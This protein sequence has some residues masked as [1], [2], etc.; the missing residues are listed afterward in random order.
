VIRL[1]LVVLLSLFA[2]P[3]FAADA[4]APAPDTI[5]GI[6][7]S[8]LAP[9][10]ATLVA[11][12]ASWAILQLAGWLRTR[13][14]AEWARALEARLADHVATAVRST[15]QTLRPTLAAAAADGRVTAEEA[16]QLREVALAAVKAQLGGAWADLVQLAGGEDRAVEKVMTAVE[17]EVH[18]MNSARPAP[19]SAPVGFV[20]AA[21][22]P[23][24]AAA[25]APAAAGVAA[26]LVAAL[27]LPFASGC[28]ALR[29]NEK[30][31]VCGVRDACV[32]CEGEMKLDGIARQVT[33]TY[34]E[35]AAETP[36]TPAATAA[37]GQ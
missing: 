2:A 19:R 21:P 11:A 27:A 8:N 32:V 6:L 7:V 16:R 25:T 4:A 13:T 1:F 29:T 5:V 14:K 10:L 34:C 23:T 9:A 20:P 22:E 17:A 3:A 36:A 18:G 30:D 12:A 35:D 31:L 28:A 15:E 37:V 24:P 26:L 33:V